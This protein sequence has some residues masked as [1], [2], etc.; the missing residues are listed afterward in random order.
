MG[1]DVWKARLAS[2]YAHSPAGRDAARRL[3]R[4]TYPA[5]PFDL[6]MA[7]VA[8]AAST[9]QHAAAAEASPPETA[10]PAT[11]G[12]SSA[13][14]AQESRIGYSIVLAAQRQ[15]IFY[16]DVRPANDLADLSLFSRAWVVQGL[17]PLPKI[18]LQLTSGVSAERD[19]PAA[20]LHAVAVLQANSVDDR[21]EALP[22][23]TAAL[24]LARQVSLP[25]YRE[26]WFIARAVQ[27]YRQFLHL[28]VLHR[29]TFIVPPYDLDLLWHLHMV[30][31]RGLFKM[32]RSP[33]QSFAM[34]LTC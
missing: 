14:A 3:W 21:R 6:D 29:R 22:V 8:D 25:H 12:A 7:A 4:A 34:L 27:R 23:A 17:S 2:P 15:G 13:E 11:A 24:R 28:K 33:S 18:T 16:Y 1:P 32:L 31:A 19:P 9:T 5:E 26:P 30:R 10:Q 20:M